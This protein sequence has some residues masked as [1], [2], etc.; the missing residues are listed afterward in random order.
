[1]A[2]WDKILKTGWRRCS[3]PVR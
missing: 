3:P 2:A 1:M